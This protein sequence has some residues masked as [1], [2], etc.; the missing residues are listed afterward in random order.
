MTCKRLALTLCLVCLSLLTG[1]AHSDLISQTSSIDALLQGEYG[2]L[3]SVAQLKQQGDTG[4]GTFEHLDG[5]MIMLDGIVYQVRSDSTIHK[6]GNATQLPFATVKFFKAD[7]SLTFDTPMTY[8]KL[9]E[10]L[11][12]L[13]PTDNYF[14]AF[15]IH[16]TFKMVKT[17]SVPRQSPPYPPLVEVVK[18]QPTWTF[19]NVTGTLVGFKCPTFT[20]GLNVPGYH[21]H[22]LRDNHTGGGHILDFETDNIHVQIDS[23]RQWQLTLPDTAFFKAMNLDKDRSKELHKVEKDK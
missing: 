11:D 17:R 4:I 23:S 18:V 3:I 19:E 21:L 13:L 20:K 22:F 2:P 15:V 6:R 8:A 14:H 5:E 10:K 7:Q 12:T 16:G 9:T 1:C